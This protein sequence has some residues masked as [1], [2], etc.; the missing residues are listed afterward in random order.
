MAQPENFNRAIDADALKFIENSILTDPHQDILY[1]AWTPI[2]YIDQKVK[3]RLL[4]LTNF[5]LSVIKDSF[6]GFSLRQTFLL[7]NLTRI[8]Y[9]PASASPSIPGQP[10]T[11]QLTLTF[12]KD[13]QQ[14]TFGLQPTQHGDFIVHLP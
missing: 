12:S 13:D 7:L 4:V 10:N 14:A 11:A 2:F 8:S 6:P 1:K 9:K 3:S 5:R